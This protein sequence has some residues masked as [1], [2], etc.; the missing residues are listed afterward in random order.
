MFVI[1]IPLLGCEEERRKEEQ[2]HGEDIVTFVSARR[3]FIPNVICM[4]GLHKRLAGMS[5]E[6]IWGSGDD[7]C[8]LF[9][10]TL[11]CLQP[12]QQF[13]FLFFLHR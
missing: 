9:S 8:R 7:I 10:T 5:R 6:D 13:C 4:T 12:V 1:F 3:R 11:L 2:Q